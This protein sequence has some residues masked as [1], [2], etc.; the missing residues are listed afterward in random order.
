M[1]GNKQNV[2]NGEEEFKKAK[3]VALRILAR[4]SRSGKEI[5]D[6]LT[7]KGFDAQLIEK[8]LVFLND[9]GYLNE[10]DYAQRLAMRLLENKKV[11]FARIEATLRDR[12]ISPEFIATT[13]SE[14]KE[15][16]SETKT[17]FQVMERRFSNFKPQT[18]TLRERNRVIQ[19]LR[20][21]GFSWET[22][23]Q[24]LKK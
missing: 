8:V 18:A 17:A 15:N 7:Q 20:Q 10:L 22:I 6:R 24:V 4:C 19:F 1:S 14:L 21:R 3:G 2:I 5:R 9:W 23:A 13:L 16:Y 11:G 12:G